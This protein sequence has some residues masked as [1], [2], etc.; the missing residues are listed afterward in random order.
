MDR[1]RRQ[2][3]ETPTE[4]G[5]DP[6]PVDPLAVPAVASIAGALAKVA[7]WWRGEAV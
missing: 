1:T 4:M 5:V 7:G 6:A 3:S 2:R